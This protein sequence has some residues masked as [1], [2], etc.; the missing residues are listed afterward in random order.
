MHIDSLQFYPVKSIAPVSVA[1]ALVEPRG[2]AGDRRYMLIDSDGQFM[3]GRQHP[4]LVLVHAT[5]T[6]TGLRI[7]APGMPSLEVNEPPGDAATIAITIWRDKTTARAVDPKVDRWFSDY[8]GQACRLVFQHTD[9]CRP[10]AAADGTC[11]NDQV[12]FADGYPVLLIGTASLSDLNQRLAVPVS[13]GRFRTNLVVATTEP[14]VEDSWRRISIGEVI[15]D[16]VKRCARCVFTT[17]DPLS[18]QRDAN[19]EP[20]KTLRGYR[21]D[22]DARGVMFGVNLIA[23]NRGEIARAMPVKVIKTSN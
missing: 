8:L 19:G 14:F 6:T 7:E 1:N 21:L 20:L 3:T 5:M 10:V 11:D 23:R 13:M 12:S 22:K 17:V 16:V 15:F 2:L 9:D 18:A 4:D